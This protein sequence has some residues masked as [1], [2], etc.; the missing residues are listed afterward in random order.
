LTSAQINQGEKMKLRYRTAGK[1]DAELLISL[2]NRSF[3]ADYLRYGECPAYGRSKEDMEAS[4]EQFP[5]TI[6]SCGETPVGVISALDQG[7]GRIYLGCLCV[8]PEYQGRGIGTLAMKRL[9]E[10]FPDWKSI[11]LI[12]PA[13]KDENI[14]FYTKK[15]GFTIS[16]EE[17]DGNVRVV[18]FLKLR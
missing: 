17:M 2:Y 12:T 14:S 11:E 4:V 18:R 13:D 7:G 1:E 10:M 15:C 3:Y 6:I 16:G 8:I 5:K 9:P